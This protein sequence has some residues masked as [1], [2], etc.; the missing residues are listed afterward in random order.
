[1]DVLHQLEFLT[2]EVKGLRV[3]FTRFDKD[4]CTEV[5][6]LKQKAGVWGAVAGLVGALVV[7]VVAQLIIHSL[8]K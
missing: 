4:T 7:T 2:E 1:M 6:L 3:D 5:A 8:T